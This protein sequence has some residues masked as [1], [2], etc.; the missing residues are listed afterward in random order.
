MSHLILKESRLSLVPKVYPESVILTPFLRDAP[1][2]SGL[3]N[4]QQ[5]YRDNQLGGWGPC[6]TWFHPG[7]PFQ[8]QRRRPPSLLVTL[9]VVI[10]GYLEIPP[11][12]LSGWALL[13]NPLRCFRLLTSKS[14]LESGVPLT[15]TLHP[16]YP[17][18]FN[19]QPRLRTL[20]SGAGNVKGGKIIFLAL[21]YA[22]DILKSVPTLCL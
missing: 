22:A 17:G 6:F 12:W 4:Q 16:T 14:K 1:T 3:G 19:M 21:L 15:R 11:W 2:S 18:Y 9:L 8:Q 5:W 10:P 7:V 20:P 13:C